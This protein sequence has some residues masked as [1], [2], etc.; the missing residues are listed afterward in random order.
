MH[1][2]HRSLSQTEGFV[3]DCETPDPAWL[4]SLFNGDGAVFQRHLYELV[5]SQSQPSTD[6]ATNDDAA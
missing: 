4:V 2:P 6:G 1:K 3:P 5:L